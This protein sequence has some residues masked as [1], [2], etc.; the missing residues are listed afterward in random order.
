MG[1]LGDRRGFDLTARAGMAGHQLKPQFE[2]CGQFCNGQHGQIVD[3]YRS[4][5]YKMVISV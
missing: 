2:V 4:M 3:A 1:Q 5:L